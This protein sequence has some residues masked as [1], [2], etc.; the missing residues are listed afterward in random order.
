MIEVDSVDTARRLTERGLG[1]AFLPATA[2]V[3]SIEAERLAAVDLADARPV[4][5]RIVALERTGPDIVLRGALE[6]PKVE[7]L[8]HGGDY[9]LRLLDRDLGILPVRLFDT[10]VAA[11]LTGEPA[12]GL[13]ALLEKY[14]GV[15]L[16][17]K[18]QRADWAARPLT[19]IIEERPWARDALTA[20]TLMGRPSL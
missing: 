6:D 8:M 13:S 2:A 4:A 9:D 14:V 16:A 19:V 3:P 1:V 5:W 18:Y 17:K 12:I 11:A 7:V 10:Q 20:L 15:K